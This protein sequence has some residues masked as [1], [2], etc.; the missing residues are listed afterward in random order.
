MKKVLFSMAILSILFFIGCSKDNDDSEDYE[1]RL[2]GFWVEN[3]DNVI[4]VFNLELKEGHTGYQWAT[5]SGKIDNQGKTLITW[6]ATKTK[7]T[8]SFDKEKTE[9]FNYQIVKDTLYLGEIV[10]IRK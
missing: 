10:Y 6:S 4:E 8:S 5:D 9:I 7:F 3:T 2:I 1:S